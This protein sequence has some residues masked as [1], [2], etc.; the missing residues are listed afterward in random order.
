MAAIVMSR[1]R[2]LLL[3]CYSLR[4]FAMSKARE[5][6]NRPPI[7]SP[8]GDALEVCL[9]DSSLIVMADRLAQGS[10]HTAQTFPVQSPQQYGPPPTRTCPPKAGS[11]SASSRTQIE[12]HR[13]I[14]VGLSSIQS[15]LIAHLCRQ[16]EIAYTLRKLD[17]LS[18]VCKQLEQLH[19]PIAS[20]YRGYLE[21]FRERRDLSAARAHLEYAF[22]HAPRYYQTRAALVLGSVA[23]HQEDYKTESECYRLALRVNKDDRFAAIEAHRAI[24][25]RAS[26]EGEHERA[27][28]LLKKVM[29]LSV[30]SGYLQAQL[31]NALAVELRA[32]GRLQEAVRLS[33]LACASLLASVYAEFQETRQEIQE[34]LAQQEARPVIVVVPEIFPEREREEK[35]E[36]VHASVEFPQIAAPL[37]TVDSEPPAL[38]EPFTDTIITIQSRLR[39]SFNPNAPPF[40]SGK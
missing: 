24:A 17:E 4:F 2:P 11:A 33:E 30:G 40:F 34:D 5:A 36:Q 6:T 19:A 9:S 39:Y 37:S 18:S 27:I 13:L 12:K 31:F 22:N 8:C 38:C 21:Q 1:S 23:N 16:A 25:I 3:P 14:I 28:D 20:Y 10:P 7:T 29:P 32:V 35:K 15:E 26:G